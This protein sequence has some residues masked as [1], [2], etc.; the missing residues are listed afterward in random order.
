MEGGLCGGVPARELCRARE[1][2]T[3]AGSPSCHDDTA[4]QHN[5][6]AGKLER[7][8][9]KLQEKGWNVLRKGYLECWVVSLATEGVIDAVVEGVVFLDKSC[10]MSD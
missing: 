6:D 1:A 10:E 3:H 7:N 4:K 2:K 8:S 5:R 9:P